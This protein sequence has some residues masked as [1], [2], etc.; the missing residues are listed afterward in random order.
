MVEGG[1]P[2]G[3]LLHQDQT[4]ADEM[5]SH[6]EDV[7]AIA[8]GDVRHPVRGNELRREIVL[9]PRRD[10]RRRRALIV[11]PAISFRKQE[12]AVMGQ[13]ASF[14]MISRKQLPRLMMTQPRNLS[15]RVLVERAM[16]EREATAL[17][18]PPQDPTWRSQWIQ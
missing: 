11:E 16:L 17:G 7:M 12:N 9:F 2:R 13:S 15:A 6:L 8:I 10:S 5:E 1:P 3:Q 14:L 4:A 18:K